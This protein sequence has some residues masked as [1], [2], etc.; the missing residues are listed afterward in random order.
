[1][2]ISFV[3]TG[4]LAI[5]LALLAGCAQ[6]PIPVAGNFDLTEQKKV[7]SAGHW[8]IIAQSAARE[9][10]KMLDEAGAAS[11]GRL[12]V[13]S[14]EKS[15]SFEK[16]FHEMLTTELVRS[17][18]RVATGGQNVLQVSYTVQLVEHKSH[19]P[20]FAP[21]RYTKLAAGVG[22]IYGL[23]NQHI[24]AALAGALAFAGVA[25]Y[26]ASTDAGGP[27]HTELVLTTSA[28]TPDQILTRK[29]DVY[30]IED[31]DKTLF[32][33]EPGKTMNVVNQ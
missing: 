22:V 25:D 5:G 1:L 4:C 2:K 30:Y 7:R 10:L 3:S 20:Q 31:L 17:G 8:Q 9:T 28:S 12:A 29:T 32:K 14:P 33:P 19:R 24:D 11:N 15:T 13:V 23:R 21:G 18:R 6:S 27:T 16:A 26:V